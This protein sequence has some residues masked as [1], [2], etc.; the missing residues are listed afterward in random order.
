MRKVQFIAVVLTLIIATPITALAVL[1]S[2][3]ITDNMGS[4]TRSL[5]IIPQQFYLLQRDLLLETEL[6]GL[7]AGT[8]ILLLIL[9]IA[10]RTNHSRI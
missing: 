5:N 2:A 8:V 1:L 3:Y 7:I 6:I 4:I 9:L 10:L